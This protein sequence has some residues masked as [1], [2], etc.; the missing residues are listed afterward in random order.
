MSLKP[1]ASD[2]SVIIDL[3]LSNLSLIPIEPKTQIIIDM[4][5]IILPAPKTKAFVFSKT[6]KATFLKSGSL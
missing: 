5:K 3:A 6:V 2:C 4:A 1:F